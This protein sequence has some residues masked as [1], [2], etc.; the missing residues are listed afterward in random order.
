MSRLRYEVVVKELDKGFIVTVGCKSIA[1][2]GSFE[3]LLLALKGYRDNPED[4][5]RKWFPEDFDE[6]SLT[7]CEPECAPP[8]AR[9]R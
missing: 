3:D 8:I 5:H 6:K 4:T 1:Y 9:A 2:T 7:R